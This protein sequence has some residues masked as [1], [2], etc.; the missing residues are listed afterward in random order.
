[1]PNVKRAPAVHP[2]PER[3]ERLV[4]NV[5]QKLLRSHGDSSKKLGPD[6]RAKNRAVRKSDCSGWWR[7]ASS[8]AVRGCR[9]L[10]ALLPST[11]VGIAA[12]QERMMSEFRIEKDS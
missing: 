2:N 9:A 12:T 10:L 5:C 6:V 1:M 11:N 8:L 3:T 7:Q 4:S